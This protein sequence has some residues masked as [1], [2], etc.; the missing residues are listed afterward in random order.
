MGH[1][2]EAGERGSVAVVS[3]RIEF[4]FGKDVTA[5]LTR[6]IRRSVKLDGANLSQEQLH[7]GWDG[8]EER[9]E[10]SSRTSWGITHLAR[11]GHHGE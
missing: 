7:A 1:A 2:I 10:P 4:L 6:K 11:K 5:G 9:A 3:V 8:I